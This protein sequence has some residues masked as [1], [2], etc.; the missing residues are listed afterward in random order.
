VSSPPAGTRYETQALVMRCGANV[1]QI[2]ACPAGNIG[3]VA[4]AL[5]DAGYAW[6]PAALD[7]N[8]LAAALLIFSETDLDDDELAEVADTLVE[9]GIGAYGYRL[10]H[11]HTV[12]DFDLFQRSGERFPRVGIIE[13]VQ[14]AG[15]DVTWTA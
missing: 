13:A 8:G 15:L 7:D 5:T 1:V 4:V 6:S 14:R 2:T 12:C 11:D 9:K 10:I 3:A